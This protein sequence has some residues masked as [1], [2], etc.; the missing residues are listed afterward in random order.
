VADRRSE[1]AARAL[2]IMSKGTAVLPVMYDNWSRVR[3][4]AAYNGIWGGDRSGNLGQPE[5]A[6]ATGPFLENASRPWA[7]ACSRETMQCYVPLTSRI[8]PTVVYR[9]PSLF[10]SCPL[11]F[12]HLLPAT[13]GPRPTSNQ[14]CRRTHRTAMRPTRPHITTP[15]PT[16]KIWK[17]GSNSRRR[18]GLHRPVRPILLMKGPFS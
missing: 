6:C 4:C 8:Q 10:I 17:N 13:L 9:C 3:E 1:R 16:M 7:L 14:Q 5:D 15:N 12:H 2:C 18:R 11:S